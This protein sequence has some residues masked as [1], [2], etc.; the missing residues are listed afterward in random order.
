MNCLKKTKRP[1]PSDR[2]LSLMNK[3]NIPEELTLALGQESVVMAQNL[4]VK[5]KTNFE[6]EYKKS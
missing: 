5:W 4:F 1:L 3:Y 6:K 2:L